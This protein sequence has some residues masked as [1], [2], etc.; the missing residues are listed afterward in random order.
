MRLCCDAL[1]LGLTVAGW[2]VWIVTIVREMHG[3]F[4]WC[5]AIGIGLSSIAINLVGI[6]A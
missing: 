1:A 3:V 4:G 5:Y 2:N 6:T